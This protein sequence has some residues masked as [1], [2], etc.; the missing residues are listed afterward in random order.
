MRL[1]NWTEFSDHESQNKN[2]L[3]VR[4]KNWTDFSDYKSQ[5]KIFIGLKFKKM[6]N[7]A[8]AIEYI[9]ICQRF[10]IIFEN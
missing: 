9:G 8:I 10:R 5:N 7:I 6:I 3:A 2:F 1:K 4:L